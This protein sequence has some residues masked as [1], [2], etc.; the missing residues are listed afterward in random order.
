MDTKR[1]DYVSQGFEKISAD[2]DFLLDCLRDVLRELGLERLA[3]NLPWG[4]T[5]PAAAAG[6]EGFEQAA[7][8]AYQLLNMVEENA[9]AAT[10]RMR[11]IDLGGAAEP[12]LWPRQLKELSASGLDVESIASALSSIRIEPVLTAHPTEAKRAA[13][14]EQHRALYTLLLAREAGGFTPAELESLRG[15]FMVVLE[16]LWRTGEILLEKPDVATE[17]RGVIYTLREVFPPALGRLDKRFLQAWR[18]AGFDTELLADPLQWPK[19]RFGTWVGGDRDGHPLVTA[20]VTE[21]TLRELRLSA[22]IALHR[23]L[24]ELASRLPLSSN[25]QEFPADL[26]ETLERLRTENPA[27]AAD[28]RVNHSDE[29]WRQFILHLQA[30]LPVTT[31]EIQ[32]AKILEGGIHFRRPAE[33]DLHLSRLSESLRG[34]GAQRLLDDAVNPVRRALHTF[35]FHLAALDIRQNSR[36]HDLAIDQLLAAS[37][38]ESPGFSNWDEARRIEFL[39]AELRSPRP[40]LGTESSAGPEADAVLSCYAVLRRHLEKNGPDGVGALIVSMTRRLSDLLAV[41]L[42]ARE[43]GLARWTPEGLVCSLPVV[44]LFETLDDLE[45]GPGIVRDFLAHPVT[46]R[47]L[48]RQAKAA[49]EAGKPV[50][51]VM[52]GYSDSN[53]DCGIFASQWA[54]HRSQEAISN[55]GREAGINIRFFHGRGGTISRGAGPTH[56]FLDA[57]PP[58]SVDGDLRMTEQGETISQK[59]GTISSSVHN[60][61]LLQSGVAGVSLGPLKPAIAGIEAEVC[62]FLSEASRDA[63]SALIGHPDFMAYFSEATPIDALETS[64]IGS[65]P[66]RRT[67]QRTLAD[68]RAIPWVF[69]WNQSRHYLPGW[70]GVGTALRRLKE[71]KPALFEFLRGNFRKSPFLYYVL[72]NVET[73]LASADPDLIGLYAGL[74]SDSRVRSTIL[75]I[76]LGEFDATRSMISG[77]FGGDME[78]RRPRMTKTLALRGAGLHALHLHQ[79][80]LLRRW[81]SACATQSPEK[82]RLL[83]RVLLSINAIA[84]GLR[85]TG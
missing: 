47:S 28:L 36:F 59:Y 48:L 8:I 60:L 57:L 3:D 58:G 6:I 80:E 34:L 10:R 1:A 5:D 24:E 45:R 33:L 70:F 31:G 7:S 29:P 79:I 26:S 75:P 14:L 44:P 66:S 27:L 65:R 22:L 4:A 11:E 23:Q 18:G 72:T 41:Y 13:V 53:K 2:L 62:E 68:L 64:R 19:V 16:R 69:G 67:G 55:A 35:G 74:V 84:S 52:I 83:P 63:Y 50:Q 71:E 49:G 32:D 38:A 20:S 25:F 46:R 37:G 40:F 30:K 21:T 61:E 81:R 15:E 12:G 39:E 56:R 77:V 42:L 85:T 17:R 51:Q 82:D 54:L 73:N 43:A 78:V 76:I 9:A